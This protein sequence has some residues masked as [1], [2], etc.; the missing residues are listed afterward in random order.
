MGERAPAARGEG[1]RARPATAADA[2]AIATVLSES[3]ESK[4]RPALGRRA[5]GALAALARAELAAGVPLYWV[6]ELSGLVVGAVRLEDAVAAPSGLLRPL[7]AA[8]GWPRALWAAFAWALIAPGRTAPDEAYVDEL[9]VA[10]PARGRGVGRALLGACEGEARRRGK[11][12]LT[13]WV[14]S[15]NAPALRLYERFGF[16]VTRRRRWLLGRLI[17]RAPG[18]FFMEKPL[19]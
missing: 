13:L 18:A 14:T 6:V 12:R 1:P 7:A 5:E 2:T 10:A 8:V 4:Y 11:R 3:L 16:R 17:F 9:G 15:D 19:L